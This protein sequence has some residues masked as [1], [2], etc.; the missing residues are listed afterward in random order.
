MKALTFQ[1]GLWDRPRNSTFCDEFGSSF[2]LLIWLVIRKPINRGVQIQNH[3]FFPGEN[4]I[5]DGLWGPSHIE[6]GGCWR[7]EESQDH[8]SPG[9][10]LNHPTILSDEG[11]GV[12]NV[13]ALEV[14][15]TVCSIVHVVHIDSGKV[16][17][18][19]PGIG[20]GRT[21][22]PVGT[23]YQVLRHQWCRDEGVSLKRTGPV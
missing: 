17:V 23:R 21:M 20:N 15:E 8:G 5:F 22:R 2:R 3:A 1:V 19:K 11:Q 4:Q 13:V 6:D 7:F 16:C 12:Q 9:W 14:M 10:A 18:A